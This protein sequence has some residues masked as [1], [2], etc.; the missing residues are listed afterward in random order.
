[1][2]RPASDIFFANLS[3]LLNV[4]DVELHEGLRLGVV[5]ALKTLAERIGIT[6]ALGSSRQGKLALWQIMA[7]LIGQGP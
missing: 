1:M 4:E 2:A 3:T 5:F 6:K 7:R